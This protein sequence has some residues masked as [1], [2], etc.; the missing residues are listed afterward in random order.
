M[1]LGRN[2]VL[3]Q[4]MELHLV[5]AKMG[6]FIKPIPVYLLDPDFWAAHLVPSASTETKDEARQD[7]L[8]R[9]ALGFL[10][11]YT[12]LIAYESDFDMAQ[13][14]G[15]LPSSLSWPAWKTICSQFLPHHS[16]AS[17][18]PRY[19]YGELRLSRLNKL[20]I[21]R[22]FLARIRKGRRS[23]LLCRYPA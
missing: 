17:L 16:Y 14:A 19:W 18:N 12:A 4:N 23:C 11:S 6:I 13:S 21:Q 10:F 2:I 1:L 7:R 5:W 9:C 22:I 3:T 15:L 8:F 20:Q